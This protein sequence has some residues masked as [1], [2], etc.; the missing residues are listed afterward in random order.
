MN[1][2]E[3]EQLV[4]EIAAEVEKHTADPARFREWLAA[5]PDERLEF[6]HR[7]LF[8]GGAA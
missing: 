2:T 3:R 7:N 1:A 6:F 5:Q 4:A 8:E